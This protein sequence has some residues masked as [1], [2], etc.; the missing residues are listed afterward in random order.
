MLGLSSFRTQILL[1]IIGL[2]SL[3]LASVFIAVN[4]ANQS[5]ARLHLEETLNITAVAFQRD[6]AARNRVL[7]DKARLLSGDFAFKEAVAT[8]DHGTILSAL[9]NHRMRVMADVMM[10]ASLE[11]ELIASTIDPNNKNLKTVWT[12]QTL[13]A[14]AEENP[15][16]EANGIQLLNGKPYQLVLM[17]LFTPE[18]SAWIVIGFQISD[19]FSQQLAEQTHSQVSLLYQHN[20]T[21][22]KKWQVFASTLSTPQQTHLLEQ[23]KNKREIIKEPSANKKSL[24]NKESSTSEEVSPS[25]EASPDNKEASPNK[26][27]S[28]KTNTVEE[29][30]LNK[31]TYLSLIIELQGA[32]EGQTLAVL[33]RSL[34]DALK[35]Y[36][37]LRTIMLT[38][39]GLGLLFAVISAIAIARSLSRPLEA[40]TQ[41][42]QRI[43]AGDYRH[44]LKLK[45]KDE[46][47]LL[48]TAVGHMSKGLQE[49]NQVRDLLGKVVSPEIASELLKKD[50]ELGGEDRHATILFSDIRKFTNFCEKRDPKNI[51]QLLNRYLS[52]MSNVV[53]NHKGVIDKYIGDAIMALYGVP[54]NIEQPAEHAVKSAL[55]MLEALEALNKKLSKEK[56][57]PIKIGIGINTGLVVAGNM[58]SSHRLNYTVIGDC[59]NLASRLEGLTKFLG[60]TI[61]VSESTAKDCPNINFRELGTVHV[62]GKDI[63]I[64]IFEPLAL[65]QLSKA[66]EQRL[67]HHHQAL[68]HFKNQEWQQ[69]Q[70]LF[71]DLY[72]S[73][74]NKD[75]TKQNDRLLYRLYLDNIDAYIEEKPISTWQGELIIFT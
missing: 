72:S 49:R 74:E 33:Q 38:L 61:I 39:F 48:S 13:Q 2:L 70:T 63:S 24:A 44:T 55:E 1:L 62:K 15:N 28:S 4:Q 36:M 67:L 71:L 25:K 34:K 31:N 64:R 29:I 43:D 6:L 47:G 51:L 52:S 18:P 50:I 8:E 69:A 53:E 45:R 9:N 17:P 7:I 40:L 54:I 20:N 3:V 66:Q 30:V 56:L 14:S 19:T 75:S 59:V 27:P 5:N 22:W 12:L 26:K 23:I 10:I 58:G 57:S 60:V 41:N 35:P 42:V 32:G 73:I 46:L 37:R 68:V 11:G 65:N 21:K 16:G